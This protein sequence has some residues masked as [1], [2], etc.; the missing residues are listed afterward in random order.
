MLFTLNGPSKAQK[1]LW[2]SRYKTLVSFFSIL[3]FFSLLIC[4][5]FFHLPNIRTAYG[6]CTYYTYV[7]IIFMKIFSREPFRSLSVSTTWKKIDDFAPSKPLPIQEIVARLF[8]CVLYC[9][10]ICVCQGSM[11][12][13]ITKYTRLSVSGVRSLATFK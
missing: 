6:L 10:H 5:R 4:V 1:L 3:F 2:H 13:G 7:H 9:I 12:V 11:T 8:Q